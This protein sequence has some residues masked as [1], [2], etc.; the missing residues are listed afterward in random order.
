L[1]FLLRVFAIGRCDPNVVCA[2]SHGARKRCRPSVNAVDENACA[3]AVGRDDE[4]S[5]KAFTRCPEEGNR[6]RRGGD[7]V[8]INKRVGRERQHKRLLRG[9]V[10]LHLDA[11]EA[12]LSIRY[13][14]FLGIFE[15]WS[16]RHE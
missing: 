15:A 6:A 11:R 13:G 7:R 16:R 14:A 12:R 1:P 2:N 10:L 9:A 3:R 4:R 5:V 8:D